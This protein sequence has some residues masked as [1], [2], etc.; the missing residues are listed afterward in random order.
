VSS[1]VIA[2]AYLGWKFTA[3][4]YSIFFNKKEN[5][6]MLNDLNSLKQNINLS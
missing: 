2:G 4:I 6:A 1:V 5:K 3:T